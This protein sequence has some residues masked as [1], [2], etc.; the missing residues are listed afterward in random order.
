[1]PCLAQS[2]GGNNPLNVCPPGP[3]SVAHQVGTG[4][5]LECSPCAGCTVQAT[6]TNETLTYYKD[7][8]CKT[9][10]LAMIADGTC[11]TV[12]GSVNG[13]YGSYMFTATV[14]DAGC[15]ASAAVLDA[16]LMSQQTLCCTQ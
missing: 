9:G 1:M 16:G 14:S 12:N 6:C 4:A 13:N 10:A 11:K 3:F 7:G 8:A 2:L 15:T 5:T